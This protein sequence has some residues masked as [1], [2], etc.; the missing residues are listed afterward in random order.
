MVA[1]KM[2]QKTTGDAYKRVAA[3]KTYKM[4][5]D[6]SIALFFAVGGDIFL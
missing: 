6:I 1:I 2:E 3:D 5:Q 4:R